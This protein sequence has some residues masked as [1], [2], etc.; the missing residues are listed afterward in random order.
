[1]SAGGGAAV[2]PERIM[3]MAWGYAAPLMLESGVR[4]GIFDLLDARPRTLDEVASETGAS[5]RG[6]RALLPA[7][8]GIGLLTRDS[9]GRY[10]LAP[11]AATFLVS[12]KPGYLGGLIRHTSVQQIGRA[13]V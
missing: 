12:G 7:L 5:T 8:A 1:M 4:N 10:G 2:T 3:Q 13:H 11:D 9:E 6:L